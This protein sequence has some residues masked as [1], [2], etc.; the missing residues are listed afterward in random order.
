MFCPDGTIHLIYEPRFKYG[1]ERYG[2]TQ[3]YD[4]NDNLLWEGKS[5]KI[6]YK[7]LTWNEYGLGED[8]R[9]LMTYQLLTPVF[10]RSLG[11]Q[12]NSETKTEE[13]WQYKPEQD[14]FVGWKVGGDR[15]GY[16]GAAGFTDSMAKGTK[17]GQLKN[18]GRV[19]QSEDAL[20]PDL[21][22]L[23]SHRLFA[24]DFT[25]RVVSVVFDSFS[26]EIACV[27][28]S[29]FVRW[30]QQR[31]WPGRSATLPF[32]FAP[33]RPMIHIVTVAGKHHLLI[34]D[35][36]EEVTTTL[37]K[38]WPEDTFKIVA[39]ENDIFLRYDGTEERPPANLPV[40]SEAYQQ[41]ETNYR[42]R[43][44]KNWAELYKVAKDGKLNLTNRF[45]WVVP[46]KKEES[47][48]FEF[49]AP[50]SVSVCLTSFS[51]PVYGIVWDLYNKE[52]QEIRHGRSELMA[53][54]VHLLDETRPRNIGL[55]I[56]SIVLIVVVTIWHG[57]ARRTSLSKLV[58]W[59]I[60]VGAF[61]LAGLLTYFA[62]NHT[63]IIKCPVCGKKRG[64]EGLNCVRC[65][66]PLP[67]PRR[68]PTDLIFSN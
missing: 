41:W 46:A 66:S 59:L 37:P 15:I 54:F 33:Y 6:P 21:L 52:L 5:E 62:L 39:F 57:W 32:V 29:Y 11:I 9:E 48:Y 19:G 61:N 50:R 24:I 38:D 3:I 14:L 42:A 31:D 45:E 65:G 51:A 4:T 60:I 12:V 1:D 35:P 34:R 7:Y 8:A 68:K 28:L 18:F 49:E 20:N 55:H 47:R 63:A 27:K 58:L 22:W 10:S 53:F 40:W 36:N 64:L 23:T 67:A 26:D 17:F 16:I 2:T 25:R 13:V 30:R 43:E 44:H 56:L